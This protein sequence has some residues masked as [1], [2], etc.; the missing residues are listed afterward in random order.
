MLIIY[1]DSVDVIEF[2]MTEFHTGQIF[3]FRTRQVNLWLTS[4]ECLI[5]Y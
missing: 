2:R 4:T 3:P 1:P 5:K